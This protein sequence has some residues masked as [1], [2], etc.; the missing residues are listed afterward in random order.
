[1]AEECLRT[2][3]MLST[4]L[5]RTRLY[6][7]L[8]PY[9]QYKLAGHHPHGKMT[10]TTTLTFSILTTHNAAAAVAL[11]HYGQT[12]RELLCCAIHSTHLRY[13]VLNP[14]DLRPINPVSD[15]IMSETDSDAESISDSSHSHSDDDDD[16]DDDNADPPNAINNG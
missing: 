12:I 8:Y 14:F 5:T 16:D 4:T 2:S 13:V 15:F 6:Y 11:C 7:E 3:C 9:R 1:M 10:T